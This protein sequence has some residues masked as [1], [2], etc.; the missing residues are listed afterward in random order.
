[1]VG[2]VCKNGRTD[3]DA[4]VTSS[5]DMIDSPTS[6]IGRPHDRPLP[7]SLIYSK[8]DRAATAMSMATASTIYRTR[9][10]TA[11]WSSI[12]ID[13]NDNSDGQTTVQDHRHTAVVSCCVRCH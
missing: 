13:V 11:I 3:Q 6:S 8:L 7:Q 9:H 2:M 4:R 10:D 5:P 12:A 1:M